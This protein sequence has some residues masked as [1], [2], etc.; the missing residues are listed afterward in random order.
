MPSFA[1]IGSLTFSRILAGIL[2]ASGDEMVV[3]AAFNGPNDWS[4]TGLGNGETRVA[5]VTGGGVVVTNDG[6]KVSGFESEEYLGRW[7]IGEAL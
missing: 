2:E 4:I 3:S 7:L 1:N 6:D 5:K